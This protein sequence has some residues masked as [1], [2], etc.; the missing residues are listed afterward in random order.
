MCKVTVVYMDSA[1]AFVTRGTH[2]DNTV[3]ITESSYSRRTMTCE[4][5]ADTFTDYSNDSTVMTEKRVQCHRY[6]SLE[7]PHEASS[8]MGLAI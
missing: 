3:H 2:P 8:L 5:I 4:H 1:F 7:C 6:N